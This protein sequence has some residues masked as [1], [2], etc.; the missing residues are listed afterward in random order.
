MNIWS[1]LS[2][3]ISTDG[4]VSPAEGRPHA[5]NDKGMTQILSRT[6]KNSTNASASHKNQDISVKQI[7]QHTQK[8]VVATRNGLNTMALTVVHKIYADVYQ[9]I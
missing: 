6:L 2:P 3:N 4:M 8:Y 9:R 5:G 7:P 1:N